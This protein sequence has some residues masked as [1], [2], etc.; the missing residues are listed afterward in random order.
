MKDKF[1]IIDVFKKTFL[2]G[3]YQFKGTYQN[4]IYFLLEEKCIIK[5]L[6]LKCF[7]ENILVG[8]WK[9]FDLKMDSW[10]G[11]ILKLNSKV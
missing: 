3:T 4:I 6:I 7:I 5:Y 11:K 1:F 2:T 10:K 9:W 8:G